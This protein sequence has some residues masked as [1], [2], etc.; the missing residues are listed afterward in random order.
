MNEL[1]L[2]T[3]VTRLLSLENPFL[4]YAVMTRLS[5]RLARKIIDIMELGMLQ[6]LNEV[7]NNV[8]R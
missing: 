7:R 1:W 8:D 6:E 4:V 3:V 5:A 2:K